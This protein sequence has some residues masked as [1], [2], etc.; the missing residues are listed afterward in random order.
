LGR[1]GTPFLF[2]NIEFI[3]CG[4]VG[5]AALP[6]KSIFIEALSNSFSAGIDSAFS[7]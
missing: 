3:P 5:I 6:V 2:T 1:I 7:K 4:L